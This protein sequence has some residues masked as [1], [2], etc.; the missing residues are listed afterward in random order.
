MPHTLHEQTSGWRKVQEMMASSM[1]L[2]H[3]GQYMA[4]T[5]NPDIAKLDAKMVD[6]PLISGYSPRR[7]CKGL[8][9]MLQKQAGNLNV[10]KLRI[11]V[12]FKVDFNGRKATSF[13]TGTMWQLEKQCHQYPK[14]KQTSL[15]QYDKLQLTDGTTL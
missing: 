6:I 11:I 15:L 9:I 5:F 1:S 8:N 10:E 12:L 7:W 14:P 3:F 4:G 2:V 13:S